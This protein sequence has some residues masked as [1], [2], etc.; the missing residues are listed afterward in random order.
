MVVEVPV[1]GYFDENCYF[2]IDDDTK[3]GFLIDPGAEGGRL[4]RLVEDHSWV[5]ERILLTHG[6]FDHTGGVE[7]VRDRYQIPVYAYEDA[8][9]YL[10]DP[11]MNLSRYCGGDQV[12]HDVIALKDGDM[13]TLSEG[14]LCLHVTYVP[15]HTTDSV[16]FYDAGQHV[17]FVGDTI[18]KGSIGTYQYPGGNRTDLMDSIV[19][20]ILTLPGETILYSG[21]TEKTTVRAECERYGLDCR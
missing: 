19:K 12:I 4:I 10:C 6:H 21:H 18:F 15:G 9:R 1:R 20:K 13:I 11:V 14:T 5:I 16:M 17:A 8:N 3:H 2:Y 7:N